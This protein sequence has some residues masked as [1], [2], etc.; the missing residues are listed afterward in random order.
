MGKNPVDAGPLRF[1]GTGG[2]IKGTRCELALFESRRPCRDHIQWEEYLN[3]L[4]TYPP[5]GMACGGLYQKNLSSFTCFIYG[6]EIVA[7][8]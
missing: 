3:L 4:F 1:A 6:N 2:L 7:L 8:K 5:I